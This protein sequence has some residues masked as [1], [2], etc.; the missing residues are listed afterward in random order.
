MP[1][2]NAFSDAIKSI[3]FIKHVFNKTMNISGASFCHLDKIKQF[4]HEI[5]D[6]TDGYHMWN[7]A[8][9]ILI[10]K[11]IIKIIDIVCDISI[12]FHNVVLE[13][14]RILDPKAWIKKYLVVAS[15]SW[16]WFDK[17]I[18]GIKHS[19]FS[20]IAIH[21]NNQFDLK[22]AREELRIRVE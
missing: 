13:A 14:N 5:D 3:N 12:L 22:I 21:I 9:P 10:I 11:L 1:P 7:G 6:I 4:N 19:K 20:S 2:S 17:V 15:V 18:N 16:N 8:S